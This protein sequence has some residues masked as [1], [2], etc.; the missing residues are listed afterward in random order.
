MR[1]LGSWTEVDEVL[2]EIGRVALEILA[3]EAEL[4]MKVLG[5][6]KEY[7][8]SLDSLNRRKSA[9]E[10]A[11]EAFCVPRKDEF[12]GKRSRQ[13][14]FGRIAFRLSEKIEIP[15]GIEGVAIRT[16]KDLG[17]NECVEVKE[18]LDRTALKKLTDEHLARCGLKRTVTDRFRIEPNLRLA[19]EMLGKGCG[20]SGVTIDM[21][22]LSGA[23]KVKSRQA[24]ADV[25][26][27]LSPDFP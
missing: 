27:A 7:G 15:A 6:V 17:W 12:T 14:T 4:G 3:L 16:L 25:P 26:E 21:E 10:S 22:K 11:I 23:V 13:F 1:E 5:M 18:R 9:I 19:A 8:S 2:E 24:P 20:T